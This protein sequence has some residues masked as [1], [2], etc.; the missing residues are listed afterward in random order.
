MELYNFQNDARYQINTLINAKRHP[1]FISP[2]G[3]GKTITAT[4]IIRDQITLKKRIY[5][6]VSQVEIFDLWV[7]E[8]ID[9]GLNPGYINDEGVRGA[10]RSVYICMTLSLF[11]IIRLI[12]ESL[13]PNVVLVDECQH[14]QAQTWQ[15]ICQYFSNSVRVGLT[16]TL[17]HGS[18]VS[19]KNVFTDIVQTITKKQAIE[20]SFIS[21][22]I[23]MVPKQYRLNIPMKGN[24]YDVEAQ[25]KILSERKII[26]N[27]I[28]FY[29]KTFHGF[30]V[31]IPCATYKHADFII[32]ELNKSGWNFKHIH[33]GLH[34]AERKK[35]LRQIINKEI[36]GI[37]TVGIGVEGMS[38]KGL[39][40]VLWLR[41]TTSPIIWTQFNGRA[42]RIL[43]G[44]KYYICADFVGNSVIHGLPDKNYTWTLEN[45]IKGKSD[46]I[47][48][49]IENIKM[50]L[51]SV[52]GVMNA[53]ENTHCHFCG[54]D[55]SIKKERQ[56]KLPTM[57]DGELVLIESENQIEELKQSNENLKLKQQEKIEAQIK[58]ESELITINNYQK[59]NIIKD[60]LFKNKRKEF[61]ET[62]KEWL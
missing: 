47:E 7:K 10:G 60:N 6:L 38:I 26:G 16:A 39:Y 61:V 9:E 50:K 4:K 19:F 21:K 18:G 40:G 62:V 24:D 25:E 53:F 58:K 44:K 46:K 33:S 31:I 52:C 23:L 51:C 36:N 48:D 32:N 37:A 8:L 57:I 14:I 1:V 2:C 55:L 12:P 20:S 30:P 41:L 3:T 43:P 5:V 27:V 22:P 11:N 29:E 15:N 34:K 45:F 28:E 13:Y 54:S 56:T 35:I 49:N 42:E 17:Y 59:V